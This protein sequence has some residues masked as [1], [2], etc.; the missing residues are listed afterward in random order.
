MTIHPSSIIEPGALLGENVSIGP[1]CHIGSEV[2]I[3][4]N[5]EIMSHVTVQ[6]NTSIGS[7]T[8]IFPFAAI[9]L[10]CQDK[11]FTGEKTALEIGEHNI[12]REYVTIHPGTKVGG[13]LTRVGNNNLL[14]V[15][16]H[17]AHDCMVGNNI[18]MANNATLGGHVCVE[19]YATLGGLCAVHQYVQIGCHA[20]ISGLS[21][22]RRD[23][24]PYGFV[25]ADEGH[26]SGLNLVGLKRRDFS[27]DTIH[28]LRS[29]YRLL[30]A[31]EGT[32]AER[33]ED[34][35]ELFNN[36]EPVMDIVRF[37]KLKSTRNICQPRHPMGD[38]PIDGSKKK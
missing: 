14:M 11:K 1:F 25:I 38:E 18:V 9:G 5:V 21:G 2:V 4:D 7:H 17:I 32:M 33:L 8:R 37:I 24:I 12:I 30:F 26:L 23:V 35:G 15:G 22:V 27:R 6:G 3:K 34:V 36:N 29:A 10:E 19:D 20:M 28:V 13:G 16:V 31:P